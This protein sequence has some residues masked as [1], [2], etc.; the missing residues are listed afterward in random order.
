MLIDFASTP[1]LPEMQVDAPHLAQYGRVYAASYEATGKNR[2]GVENL[3]DYLACYKRIG[4]RHVVI[5][6]R[7][8]ETRHGYRV[9][10]EDVA[11]FCH[12]HGPCFLGFAGVDPNKGV[13]ALREL[14]FAIGE[15]GLR[16]LNLQ[17]FELGL[18]I[19]DARMFPFYAKCIELD[20][21]LNL[22]CSTS[23]STAAAMRLGHPGL[24]DEV[25]VYFPELRVCA[26]PPG[27][28]WVHELL[29]VAM[30]HENLFIGLTAVRPKYL[31]VPE[32]GYGGLLQ[33]GNTILQDR[34]IWGSSWPMLPIERSLE[35]IDA[36]PLKDNVKRK[37]LYN[38][39]ARFLRLE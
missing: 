19:N 38:N 7:D 20:I 37:W 33:Y 4:A 5:K 26:A 32:S 30:R 14:D 15:L 29:A 23:F 11:S 6:G 1:P 3:P 16:G 28:P 39:A 36:L 2:L 24:L 27:W 35:E 10:N 34:I 8:A 13:K 21:P 22:H 25:M 18:P 9:R 12:A 31:A 17:T